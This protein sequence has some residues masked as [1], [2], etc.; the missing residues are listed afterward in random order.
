MRGTIPALDTLA[1]MAILPLLYHWDIKETFLIL[2]LVIRKVQVSLADFKNISPFPCIFGWPQFWP[3]FSMA[4]I[5]RGLNQVGSIPHGLSP[6][7]LSPPG[8]KP[9]WPQ[10]AGHSF[11]P[12]R[13]G[14][15]NFA[16]GN[17]GG[18]KVRYLFCQGWVGS[19]VH[20]AIPQ[21]EEWFLDRQ[22]GFPFPVPP[23]APV[24][25]LCKGRIQHGELIACNVF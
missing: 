8:F 5:H 18:T 9:P 10:S 4:S 7:G 3:H 14:E 19:S 17:R 24:C 20:K 2:T 23:Y 1:R 6:P 21:G 15:E 11:L 13:G 25:L 16:R 22:W 12:L